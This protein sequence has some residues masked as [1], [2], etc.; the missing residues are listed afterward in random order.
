MIARISIVSVLLLVSAGV[1]AKASRIEEV[2]PRLPFA[3]FPLQIRSLAWPGH[4]AIQRR[5]SES[6]GR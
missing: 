5:D 4:R 2:P 6:A 3:Q 1:I